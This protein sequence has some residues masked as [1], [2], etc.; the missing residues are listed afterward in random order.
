MRGKP[1]PWE[2]DASDPKSKGKRPTRAQ[3]DAYY[4]RLPAPKW[5]PGYPVI[6]PAY[7]AKGQEAL[8]AVKVRFN[9]LLAEKLP[10]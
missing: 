10:K 2:R 3:L 8:N 7:E 1:K 4:V 5:V 6:R 9:Q